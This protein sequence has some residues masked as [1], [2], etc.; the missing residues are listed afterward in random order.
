M[1]AES[2]M[3]FLAI[4]PP[5]PVYE[6]MQKIKEEF[7]AEYNTKAALRSPPHITLHM[8]FTMEAKKMENLHKALADCVSSFSKFR[9]EVKNFGAF[10]P[11]VVF[12]NVELNENLSALH[13]EIRDLMKTKFNILNQDYKTRPFHPHITIAF[14]DLKKSKYY[15]AW[16][17]YSREN[18]TQ[19]FMCENICILKHNGKVWEIYREIALAN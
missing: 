15:E 13:K 7:A 17:K 12:V 14:R 16:K 6:E 18:Y 4:V 1:S 8:P 5:S 3:F 9:I 11:R 2:F 19:E 10:E